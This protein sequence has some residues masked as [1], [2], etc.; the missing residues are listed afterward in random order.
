MESAKF[1]REKKAKPLFEKLTKVLRAL[2]HAYLDLKKSYE[3]LMENYTRL[4]Q[5]YASLDQAFDRVSEENKELKSVADDYN[6]LC[7]GCGE[8]EI[9]ARVSAIKEM[10]AA[11]RKQRRMSHRRYEIGAR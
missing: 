4:Q 1:Y 3:R 7:R 8:D 2:F 11:E 6:A 5:R 10:E 9:S